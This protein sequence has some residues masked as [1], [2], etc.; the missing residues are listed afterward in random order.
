MK[1]ATDNTNWKKEAEMISMFLLGKISIVLLD[2]DNDYY[3]W[4]VKHMRKE[5]NLC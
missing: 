2:R 1:T 3:E 4:Y 5:Y